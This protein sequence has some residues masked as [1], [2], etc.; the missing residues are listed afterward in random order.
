[1]VVCVG[2]CCGSVVRDV[3]DDAHALYH[4]SPGTQ[5]QRFELAVA[6]AFDV[7][8]ARDKSAGGQVSRAALRQLL[9][10]VSSTSDSTGGFAGL[11]VKWGVWSLRL[12]E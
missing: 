7:L 10:T 2:C 5:R 11:S 9:I 1:M 3:Y 6:I 12:S 4:S 8:A